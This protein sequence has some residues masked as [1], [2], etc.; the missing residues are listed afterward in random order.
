MSN[1]NAKAILQSNVVDTNATSIPIP[2]NKIALFSTKYPYSVTY[3]KTNPAGE[4]IKREI[5]SVTGKSGNNLVV[6][7]R[8]EFCPFTDSASTQTKTAVT[9]DAGGIIEERLTADFMNK[10]QDINTLNVEDIRG[11]NLLPNDAKFYRQ[12]SHWGFVER[13]VVGLPDNGESWS[14]VNTINKWDSSNQGHRVTQIAYNG[15]RQIIRNSTSP[16]TW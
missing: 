12:K 4:V 5:M 1:N 9:L 6:S 13:A 11:Q 15:D 7:R 10:V 8:S 16:T 14:L 2:S 3:E